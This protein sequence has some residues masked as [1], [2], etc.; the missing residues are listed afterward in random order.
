MSI[1][2]ETVRQIQEAVNTDRLLETAV[3]LVE[4]P[5]PTRSA[6]A[7][8]NR[9][10]EIIR[11]DRFEVERPEAGWPDAPAVVARFH[12]NGSG[13]TLQFNGHLDTVHLPFV[14][15]RVENG[16]LYG[17]GASDMKGGIAAM[18]EA[19]RV[20]QETDLLPAG[21]VL[22]TAHDL[23]ETPWGDGSHVDALIDAGYIG[24][25]VLL[26]EYLCDRLP[27]IGRGL[28]VLE[29][30][31]TRSGAAVHEVLGGI[32]QPNVI[33]AGAE[34]IRRFAELDRQLSQQTHP[35]AGRASLFVGRAA[36]GEIYNQSPIEF[37]LSGTRR[38]LPGTSIEQ[39]EREYRAILTEVADAR[40]VTVE[41]R[42]QLARDAFQIDR[43]DPLVLAVQ[44]AYQSATGRELPI[45]AKPFVD[46]GNSFIRRGGVPAV[47][48]GPDAKGAHTLHEEVSVDELVRVAV[49]YALTAIAF[50][51]A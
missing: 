41:G 27:V 32:D 4:V 20:L 42:F 26:P 46:D 50:C 37:Q 8:A 47:T 10:D 28:A 23:H 31:V 12:A 45:G 16:K 14:P 24:D 3:R 21:S 1:P 18:V 25:G 34:V 38:W 43:E 29:V 2:P 5:S 39:V 7:V 33:E 9:L 40:G 11:H 17:S 48:H 15:P 22:L 35:L 44:A 49:V 19:M 51:E 13:R 6:A 30:N 36:G